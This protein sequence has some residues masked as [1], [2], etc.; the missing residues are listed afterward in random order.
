MDYL[1]IH[2]FILALVLKISLNIFL[3]VEK[4]SNFLT[5]LKAQSKG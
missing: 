2:N 3:N 4:L 1:S 5:R